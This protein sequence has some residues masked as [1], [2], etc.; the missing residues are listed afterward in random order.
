M[1]PLFTTCPSFIAATLSV[2]SV[3]R[4]SAMSDRL[5]RAFFAALLTPCADAL[6]AS[7]VD[8]DS[9]ERLWPI[10]SFPLFR[11]SSLVFERK[12]SSLSAFTSWSSV[13]S[14]STTVSNASS[15][16]SS[17]AS[18]TPRSLVFTKRSWR[19]ISPVAFSRFLRVNHLSIVRECDRCVLMRIEMYPRK[20][21]PTPAFLSHRATSRYSYSI[22]LP[23]L[24]NLLSTSKL[25]EFFSF[26][27]GC[28]DFHTT[29]V[30]TV[31]LLS[32]RRN[33]T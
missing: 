18:M 3:I 20:V 33:W 1:K 29:G 16:L 27:T 26:H 11:S 13:S 2:F 14:N 4:F 28:S 21:S 32:P 15:M 9:D 7:L 10:A 24:S 30:S 8:V 5:S 31:F 6:A 22:S 23:C 19:W 25:K 12:L 17:V